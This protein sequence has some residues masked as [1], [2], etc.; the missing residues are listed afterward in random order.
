ML[1]PH[2]SASFVG[3]R[4]TIGPGIT[5]GGVVTVDGANVDPPTE[6]KIIGLG[7]FVELT[8]LFGVGWRGLNVGW[9]AFVGGAGE[10]CELTDEKMNGPG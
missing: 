3:S 7:G 1:I 2:L 5:V 10:V 8:G 4:L 6:L 9:P